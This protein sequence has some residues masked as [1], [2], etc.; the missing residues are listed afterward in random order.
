M[1]CI[2]GNYKKE[3][4]IKMQKHCDDILTCKEKRTTCFEKNG[5][6]IVECGQCGHRF[7]QLQNVGNHLDE[8]YSDD[9]FFAGKDGYPNYLD[10]KD[11]LYKYG[12][13]YA[14]IVG[15]HMQP[16]HVLDAG[17]AAGFILKGF[18]DAGW[19]CHGIEPNQTMAAYGKEQ[20][21]LDITVGGLETFETAQKF[22]L[23]N[24]IQV[25][26]HF[27]NLDKALLNVSN[28]LKPQGHV[29]VE[30]WNRN[31]RIARVMGK[32][33]H[34]Y[35]PPSVVHWFSDETII[36]LFRYYGFTLVQ[37][38]YPPKRINIKHALSLVDA[39]TP[40]FIFKKKI[41]KLLSNSVGRL[42][43][44]YP[45]VDLKWYLFKKETV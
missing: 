1:I 43:V 32:N 20:L 13:S 40:N 21:H 44:K 15:R 7:I 36:E 16:G 17:C 12:T 41:I 45:P 39:K 5:Y 38:G 33:W 4:E 14:K 29:L 22:D 26:G 23:I 9:Y 27:Y 18:E 28:L 42:N 34:E 31:S 25:I 6:P 10:E 8:V 19:K 11:M 37:K 2:A 35:S 3:P 24:M 30:S